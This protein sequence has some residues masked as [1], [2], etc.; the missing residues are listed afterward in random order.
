[1][2]TV[3]IALFSII[4][5]SCTDDDPLSEIHRHFTNDSNL[6]SEIV[7]G[8]SQGDPFTIFSIKRST[9][10]L[11]IKLGYSGGCAD[12]DFELVWNGSYD[13][14]RER[15]ITSLALIHNGNGDICEAYVS[16]TLTFKFPDVFDGEAPESSYDLLF[17]HGYNKEEYFMAE[18]TMNIIQGM[19]CNLNAS[20]KEVMCGSGFFDNRW[21]R[22]TD[23]NLI[24]G[25]DTFYFQ[26]V[27]YDLDDIPQLGSYGLSVRIMKAYIPDSNQAICL[28]YPGYSIPVKITCLNLSE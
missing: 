13:T 8:D 1:M 16:E 12:H 2:K 23:D 26:P 24:S 7:E 28:A 5:S 9:N 11:E 22:S 27:D 19:E 25:H 14:F 15:P 18:E 20:Y 10:A 21:F 3:Y 6:F 4:L 17:Y